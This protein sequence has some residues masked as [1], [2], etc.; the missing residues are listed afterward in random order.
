MT[1]PSA[2]PDPKPRRRFL[3]FSLRT[4]FVLMTVFAVWFGWKMNKAREQAKAVAWV[5][6]MGGWVRYDYEFDQEDEFIEG[7]KPPGPEWLRE[8]LGIDFTDD[9]V[10]VNFDETQV[11][12]LTPLAGMKNLQW[13]SLVGTQVGDLTPLAELTGLQTLALIDVPVNNISPIATLTNLRVLWLD[14]TDVN[15][16][17]PVEGL[18]QLRTLVLLNHV[19][20]EEDILKHVQR[21]QVALPNCTIQRYTTF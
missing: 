10:G 14:Y 13:L 16:L 18:G 4:L 8:V 17:K 2:N 12:D 20:S 19:D 5:Q 1:S 21:L 3:Q 7:A 6:E 15:D 11:S 9:V